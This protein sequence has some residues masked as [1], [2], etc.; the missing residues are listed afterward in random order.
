MPLH[1][2]RI[3]SFGIGYPIE[4]AARRRPDTL[5]A[6][7]LAGSCGATCWRAGRGCAQRRQGA[8][9]D[10]SRGP[11]YPCQSCSAL[12]AR[13]SLPDVAL[14]RLAAGSTTSASWRGAGLTSA[15]YPPR[16][17]T[18]QIFPDSAVSGWASRPARRPDPEQPPDGTPRWAAAGAPRGATD[19]ARQDSRRCHRRGNPPRAPEW[20]VVV[21][22]LLGADISTSTFWVSTYFRFSRFR[23]CVLGVARPA[24]RPDP[25]TA[26]RRDSQIGFRGACRGGTDG[27]PSGLQKVPQTVKSPT[28]RGGTNRAQPIRT[29]TGRRPLLGRARG[30]TIARDDA[31]LCMYVIALA[32]ADR[33]PMC[34]APEI[35]EF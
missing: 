14:A 15:G 6:F 33:P 20:A 16:E 26:A 9:A 34:E 13:G 31:G 23:Y 12:P 4:H 35:W 21:R 29:D 18:E 27:T 30:Q 7:F 2:M 19:G 22:I 5:K 17:P 28:T 8:A 10:A 25:R 1:Y 24:H 32:G 3:L 11:K